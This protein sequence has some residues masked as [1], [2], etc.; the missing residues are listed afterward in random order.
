MKNIVRII[1]CI[2]LIHLII[3]CG[4]RTVSQNPVSNQKTS[5]NNLL[6]D[7][8]NNYLKENYWIAI[9]D[10]SNVT[11]RPIVFICFQLLDNQRYVSFAMSPNIIVDTSFTNIVYCENTNNKVLFCFM[12]N[13]KDSL[14]SR[15]INT[16]TYPWD[17]FDSQYSHF[18][19][20]C[21]YD[22]RIF[23]KSYKIVDSPNGYILMALKYPLTDWV[24][25][26]PPE[27]Y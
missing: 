8:L 18:D 26:P 1:Y 7:S 27:K 9:E 21:F 15:I 24:C 3:G 13:E 20:P 23:L 4:H 6:I 12:F 16:Y 19:N 25:N 22:G 14:I 11:C 5:L 10:D 17:V 2:S